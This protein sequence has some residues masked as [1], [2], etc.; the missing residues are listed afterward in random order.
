M[1]RIY[2]AAMMLAVVLT[3]ARPAKSHA[4]TTSCTDTYSKCLSDASTQPDGFWR[5]AAE[6][7]CGLAYESCL[8]AKFRFW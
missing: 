8:I 3:F 6:T 4:T 5:T 2:I 1:K 7:E